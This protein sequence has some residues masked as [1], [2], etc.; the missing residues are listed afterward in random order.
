[1]ETQANLAERDR[2]FKRIR[3]AMEQA[4]LNALLVAGKGHWWTGRGYLRYLTDFHLWGHDG[5]LLLPFED[6]PV[7]TL[8]SYAVAERIGNRGWVTDTRGDVYLV[9]NMVEAIK[10]KGLKQAKIGIAG[11][12]WILPAGAYLQLLEALPEATF[13]DSDELLNSVR[14]IRSPLEIQQTRELWDLSKA[15]MERFVE[16][17]EPG[18]SQRE[19]AAEASRLVLAGGGR[20]ILVFIGERPG[21][22]N[23][24]RDIPVRCDDILRYHMEI[25][26]TSGH[27]SEITVT[28]AFRQPTEL[29]LKLMDS[30]LR[31][32]DRIR[33][34]AGP[35]VRLSDL[36]ST[37]EQTLIEDGWE[38]GPATNHFDFHGQ[39]MDT[40][41]HPWFAAAPGW[42]ASQDM[43][44]EAGMV[45]SYHPRRIVRPQVAWGTGINEDILITENG[46]DRLSGEWN[47]RW[48]VMA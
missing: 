18:K 21:D 33:E 44:L 24:P 4:G 3:E 14:M 36:A 6:E 47:L 26:G 8:T 42:G 10:E 39:G 41:E 35:S 46:V 17:L 12:R 31:A 7:L 5:L 15:A 11:L 2:R 30:E 20:D 48:R 34:I 22:S 1:M 40:I 23:P 37:F 9:P 16:V 27:W 38:L 45:F 25:C 13:V 32:Y 29:E 43:E 19:L 28:C